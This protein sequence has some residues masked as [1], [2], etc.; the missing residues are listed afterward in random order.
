MEFVF[1]FL[2]IWRHDYDPLTALKKLSRGEW[3]GVVL[4]SSLI[5]NYFNKVSKLSHQINYVHDRVTSEVYV[6]Y[7]KKHSTLTLS[8]K[9]KIGIF[10]EAGLINLW[11]AEYKYEKKSPK[12]KRAESLTITNISAILKITAFMYLISTYIFILELL[13]EKYQW[14]Q[15]FL[16]YLT[17]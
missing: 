8:F 3:N 7:F 16:D 5:V 15:K 10:Y 14:I 6:F 2:R 11:L 12:H 4:T 13:S 9:K 17:Y 1:F